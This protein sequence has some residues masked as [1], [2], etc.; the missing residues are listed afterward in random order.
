MI[1]KGIILAGGKGSRLS[2]LTKVIN[3]QLLPLYDKP[4]IFYPL[5]ILMLAGIRDI[6]IITNPGEEINFKKIFKF[7]NNIEKLNDIEVPEGGWPGAGR[8]PEHGSTY[9]TDE[10]P[11]GRDPL[12]KKDISKSIRLDKKISHDYK[13]GSPLALENQELSKEMTQMVQSM[14]GIKIK[15]KSIISESLKKPEEKKD[16]SSLLDENVLFEEL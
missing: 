11:F 7:W 8:P 10:S 13:G 9:N 14:N 3:K 4:L 2:P 16:E 1:K 6:L 5:S 15:T 12:G